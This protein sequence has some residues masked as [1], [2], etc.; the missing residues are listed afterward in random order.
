[1]HRFFSACSSLVLLTFADG[2]W[3]QSAPNR[4][5]PSATPAPA[6]VVAAPSV[7]PRPQPREIAEPEPTWYGWQTFASD[8]A[9]VGLFITA[10]EL[11]DG[12]SPFNGEAPASA[13]LA[14][15]LGTAGYAAGGPTIHV[16]HGRP[17]AAVGSVFLRVGLPILGGIVGERTATC[18]PGNRDY[19]NCGM[20]QAILGFL[21]G[22]VMA[23]VI[24]AAMLS[25]ESPS[26]KPKA[27]A[28]P[29]LGFAPVLASDGKHGELRLFGTF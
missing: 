9:S 15:G 22:V 26:A 11:S 25:W 7:T 19:G 4:S 2:S 12:Y 16:L 6:L 13:N 5:D 28:G 27:A 24:D 20:G 1:M 21:G 10:L 18:L 17:G 23:S 3:A 14:A 8:A 29:T